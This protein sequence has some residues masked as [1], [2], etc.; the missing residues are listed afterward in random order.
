[1]TVI[2]FTTTKQPLNGAAI[3]L[4]VCKSVYR[5]GVYLCGEPN[6]L[7]PFIKIIKTAYRFFRNSD[8]K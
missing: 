4:G 8:L 2:K 3:F 6:C 1:M 7:I 5:L